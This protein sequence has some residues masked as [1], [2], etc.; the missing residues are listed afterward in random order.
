M[1]NNFDA[2]IFDLDGTLVD[3]MWMWRSIDIEYLE[4]HGLSLPGNLQSEIE[5]MS[6]TQTAHY[7]KNRFNIKDD[8]EKIK[9]DWNEMAY[10]SYKHKVK[11]KQGVTD[12]LNYLHSKG[13]KLGIA[14]SNSKELT[15]AC[16]DSLNITQYFDSIITGCD[17][18]L[19]KPNPEIYLTNS[20]K[21]NVNPD[22]CFVF[23]DIPVGIIAGKS[24][25][26]TTC[27]VDDDYSIDLIKEKERL[28]DYHIKN[29][30]E[31]LSKYCS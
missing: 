3:S 9:N 17:V 18:T 26:M 24:A 5:G 4:R 6:F 30:N 7:F 11:L 13:K 25:G 20:K 23:E 16:I 21:L 22:R 28:A 8:I 19:G 29:Y 14:T 10:D 27:A 31:F 2:F 15:Y 12:I 1:V